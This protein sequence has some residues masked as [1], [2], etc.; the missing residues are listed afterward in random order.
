MSSKLKLLAAIAALAVAAQA[1]AQVT[2]YEHD[3]YAG[4][5]F[6][7]QRNVNNLARFGFN[8]LASSVVVGS[9]RWEFCENQDF[10]GRCV[11]LRRG[12]YLSLSAMGL[13]DRVTSARAVSAKANYDDE[14]YGPAPV[15]TYDARRRNNERLYEADVTSVRAVMGQPQQRCWVEQQQVEQEGS[16]ANVPGALMGALIGGVLGHQVGGGRGRDLATVG[17]VVAGG[18]VGSRIGGNSRQART[19][20]VQR[21]REEAGNGRPAYW[22]VA[23][24][25]RGRDHHMQM[26]SP[27]GKTVTV[28]RQGEPRT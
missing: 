17:G 22:D 7:T 28:N 19:Q 25:F 23:Y 16:N 9:E 1:G 6:K 20:E 13:N 8:D 21:C 14:R 5:T 11:I 27:P 18:V 4:R 10:G 2:F 12:N 3:N 26:S 15:S 24:S